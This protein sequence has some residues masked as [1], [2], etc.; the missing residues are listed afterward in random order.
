VSRFSRRSWGDCLTS[1]SC[2]IEVITMETADSIHDRDED[3]FGRII[4]QR[5]VN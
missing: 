3:A 5:I 2:E 4:L 1:R